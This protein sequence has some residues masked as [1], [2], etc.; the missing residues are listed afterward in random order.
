MTE[1]D[2][3]RY[4]GGSVIIGGSVEPSKVADGWGTARR[5]RAE[6]RAPAGAGGRH[7]RPAAR[8]SVR[9]RLLSDECVSTRLLVPG[10]RDRPGPQLEVT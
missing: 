5:G 1:R 7:R 4:T 10:S 9:D 3:S 8:C 2:K 6:A